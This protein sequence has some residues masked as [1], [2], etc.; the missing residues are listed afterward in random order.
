MTSDRVQICLEGPLTVTYSS[1]PTKTLVG[2]EAAVLACLCTSKNFIRSRKWLAATIWGDL[3]SETSLK[4]LRQTLWKL[5]KQFG[6]LA[7]IEADAVSIRLKEALV[8]IRLPAMDSGD[9]F[10]EGI[11]LNDEAFEDWLRTTRSVLTGNSG[12]GSNSNVAFTSIPMRPAIQLGTFRTSDDLDTKRSVLQLRAWIGQHLRND[13]SIDLIDRDNPDAGHAKKASLTQGL[14]QMI[15]VNA[16]QLSESP[17]LLLIRVV[18]PGNNRILWSKIIDLTL[19]RIS[20]SFEDIIDK[21]ARDVADAT[22]SALDVALKRISPNRNS[23]RSAIP[24]FFSMDASQREAAADAFSIL[25][26]ENP[27]ALAWLAY[28]KSVQVAERFGH[29]PPELYDEVHELISKAE[30][31]HSSNQMIYA[32]SGHI[33]ALLFD[34]LDA[35]AERFSI[36]SECFAS[37][38]LA[39]V[40]LAMFNNYI[41]QPK[42]AMAIA[43]PLQK[44]G[45]GSKYEFIFKSPA[46]VGSFLSQ[47]FQSTISLGEKIL[48]TQPGFL[49]AQRY[50][51][52]SYALE[53]SMRKADQCLRS[54]RRR[55]KDFSKDVVLSGHY[56]VPNKTAR[57]LIS[58]A[59]FKLNID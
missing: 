25:S 22:F 59:F 3:P 55:D 21:S 32:I 46:M 7:P 35:A 28:Q 26:T 11:D 34:D 14:L 51:F 47:D 49:G 5:K 31:S 33:H 37:P 15:E 12:R 58:T 23:L 38:T 10:L 4:R 44:F 52:A 17:L 56:P 42:K 16:E 45:I 50:L 36:V 30:E 19:C 18:D 40:L 2:Y 27:E 8:E 57:D 20:R 54:I 39:R 53:G 1:S 48:R 43:A 13:S 29:S 9:Q 24:M 41:D 6:D